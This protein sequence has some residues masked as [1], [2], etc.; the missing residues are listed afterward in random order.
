MLGLF[1]WDKNVEIIAPQRLRKTYANLLD[2]LNE[3]AETFSEY[4]TQT[5]EIWYPGSLEAEN[6]RYLKRREKALNS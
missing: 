1:T 6:R 3:V 5:E 2:S 4:E